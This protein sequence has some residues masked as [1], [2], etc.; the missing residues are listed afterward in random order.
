VIEI[1]VAFD[2]NKRTI[3]PIPDNGMPYRLLDIKEYR[4]DHPE[5]KETLSKPDFVCMSLE[6]R[7][8]GNQ[9]KGVHVI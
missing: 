8:V 1:E 6:L 7:S 3:G 5:H 4:R 9:G 2:Y